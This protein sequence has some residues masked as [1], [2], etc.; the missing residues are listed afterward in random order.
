MLSQ[1]EDMKNVQFYQKKKEINKI[2][3]EPHVWRIKK[4]FGVIYAAIRNYSI[5]Q[6]S[7]LKILKD[8][9]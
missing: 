3:E 2:K 9:Y 5:K 6:L 4:H 1:S 7:G 8:T